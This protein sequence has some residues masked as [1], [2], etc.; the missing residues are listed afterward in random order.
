MLNFKQIYEGWRNN[1]IPPASIKELIETTANERI[2]ICELCPKHSAN[3]KL[4]GY[5]TIRP[6]AHCVECGCTLA[7][8]TKCLS[9]EC[10]LKK[11][12]AQLTPEQEEHIK[13]S[14]GK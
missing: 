7:A 8:K 2:R 5:E 12:E 11:W 6:D 3:A 9:C 14:N 1:L 4:K 13:E 10:P